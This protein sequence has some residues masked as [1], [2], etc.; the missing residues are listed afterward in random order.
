MESMV[1]PAIDC[2]TGTETYGR[3]V[4]EPLERGYGVTLGNALRRVLLGSLGGAA[5]TWVRIAEVQHEFSTIPH[6]QEDVIELLLSV[7]E[8]RLRA[9]S[10][11]PGKLI[12]EVVGEG[13]VTAADIVATSDYEIV[14]PELYLATL[15]SPEATLTME[16]NVEQGRGY[17]PAGSGD[18]LSIGV[19]P[20]DAI[21][22]P[23]R[24][25][26][27]SV[28]HTRIGQVTTY[29]RLILEVWTDGTVTPEEAV[30]RSAEILIAQFSFFRDLARG[31][32][33]AEVDL[34][35]RGT[36]LTMQQYDTLV[37]E[38]GLSV[39]AY[40]CL[41][42]AGIT[43][44]GETLEKSDEELLAIRNFGQKSLDELKA[45]LAERGFVT[46]AVAMAPTKSGVEEAEGEEVE[47]DELEPEDELDEAEEE[48]DQEEELG[49]EEEEQE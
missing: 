36:G 2:Q 26:S 8:M 49:E 23:I 42:R 45:R 14:N 30:S 4:V 6:V 34:T 25:A 20:V 35:L 5:V 7:K 13:R 43:K 1:T 10:D 44:V 39:R 31:R 18:G 28:E 29:E 22:T 12:L 24:R 21:F 37:E 11:R 33:P 40:N 41:K 47:E 38:L 19:I 9:L 48:L 17:V 32:R 27:Y 16:L 15:D 3:F 46:A